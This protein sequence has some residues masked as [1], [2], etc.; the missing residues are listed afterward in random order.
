[1]FDNVHYVNFYKKHIFS[2]DYIPTKVRKRGLF[3]YDDTVGDRG[4]CHPLIAPCDANVG[5]G[6]YSMVRTGR[7]RYARLWAIRTVKW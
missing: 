1:M 3:R 7:T 4:L 2:E 5:S 6:P